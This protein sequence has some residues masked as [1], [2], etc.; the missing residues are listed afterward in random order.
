MAHAFHCAACNA[1][2]QPA[3]LRHCLGRMIPA[4]DSKLRDFWRLN[5]KAEGEEIRRLGLTRAVL[6]EDMQPGHPYLGAWMT[7]WLQGFRSTPS[8]QQKSD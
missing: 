1:T 3:G 5:G 6:P 7:G 2:K 8:N 4:D